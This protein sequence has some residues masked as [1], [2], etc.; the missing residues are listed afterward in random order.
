MGPA[1]RSFAN[2]LDDDLYEE[3]R[4]TILAPFRALNDCVIPVAGPEADHV[5]DEPPADTLPKAVQCYEI[6]SSASILSI[7]ARAAR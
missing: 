3:V 1:V 4:R 2:T 6:A 7:P 5:L